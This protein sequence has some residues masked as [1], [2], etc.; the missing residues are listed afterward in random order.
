MKEPSSVLCCCGEAKARDIVFRGI[1]V[2]RM[3]NETEDAA[4]SEDTV[5][6]TTVYPRYS[7]REERISRIKVLGIF[8][9]VSEFSFSNK[10]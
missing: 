8:Q 1:V 9:G 2:A 6:A 10:K 4:A 3:E 7:R 5:N